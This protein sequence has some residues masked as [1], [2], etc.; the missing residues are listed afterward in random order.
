MTVKLP[1]TMLTRSGLEVTPLCIGTGPMSNPRAFGYSVTAEESLATVRETFAGPVN[2]I[3]TA[4]AY[5]DGLSERLIGIVRGELGGTP[6]GFVI[7][8]KADRDLGSGDFSGAQVRRSVM[9]S[10]AR[11]GLDRLDLVYLHD[12]EHVGFECTVAPD[13]ALPALIRLREE[14]VIGSL[15]VAGGPIPLLMRYIDVAEVDVVLTHNRYTLVDRSATPLVQKAVS[16]GT[17]IVNAA[18]FG[19]GMLVKGTSRVRKYAYRDVK[20]PTLAAVQAMEAVCLQYGVPLA[21]AALQFSTRD[22]RISS[23]VIGVSRPERVRELLELYC[24][25][26]PEQLWDDLED[27][28]PTREAWLDPPLDAVRD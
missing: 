2:W 4:A 20:E 10:C 27:S 21:A 24:I 12:P 9:A 14:G 13:G 16:C 1:K 18:V 15:G 23:T 26:I 19:G 11:L 28:L 25:P 17:R 5:G 8:T 3:D 22:S 7:A 6:D